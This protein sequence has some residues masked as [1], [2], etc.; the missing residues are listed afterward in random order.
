VPRFVVNR[1]TRDL[2]GI[3][4]SRRSSERRL[5]TALILRCYQTTFARSAAF[6]SARATT[7]S[8][9]NIARLH[10]YNRLAKGERTPLWVLSAISCDIQ[11]FFF[12]PKTL[13]TLVEIKNR[14]GVFDVEFADSR[15][16]TR[17]I[18]ENTG[19]YVKF[20]ESRTKTCTIGENG[21]SLAR[22]RLR[23]LPIW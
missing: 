2:I 11:I 5:I 9:T 7:I 4:C 10:L 13:R 16:K 6:A 22:Y 17:T 8:K 1:H 23:V 19:K 3:I 21:Y 20:V 14:S 12:P 15:M 18:V